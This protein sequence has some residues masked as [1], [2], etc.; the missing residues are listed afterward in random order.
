MDALVLAAHD[1]GPEGGALEVGG[2]G[3]EGRVREDG[4]LHGLVHLGHTC[5]CGKEGGREGR[6]RVGWYRCIFVKKSPTPTQRAHP[7]ICPST[8]PS[9]QVRTCLR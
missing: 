7:P 2:Q 6:R 1:H 8:H 9:I 4:L 3:G 5:V